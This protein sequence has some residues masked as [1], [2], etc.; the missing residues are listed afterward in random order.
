[1]S[2]MISVSTVCVLFT[3]DFSNHYS[4]AVLLVRTSAV[5]LKL[6]PATHSHPGK[7]P[8]ASTPNYFLQ[9]YIYKHQ[10]PL[11]I[12]T[13]HNPNMAVYENHELENS[14][15]RQQVLN[16]KILC[17]DASH[18]V[19]VS[20]QHT[21]TNYK[22]SPFDTSKL[23]PLTI[24]NLEL[25]NSQQKKAQLSVPSNDDDRIIEWLN[26]TSTSSGYSLPICDKI[27]EV[28]EETKRWQPRQGE[29]S[30]RS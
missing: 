29:L 26:S 24:K 11:K 18:P 17:S 13:S 8:M 14:K 12:T 20:A 2:F 4:I 22:N 21:A 16:K 6:R 19:V 15:K 1:M 7:K 9:N 30:E 25:Y 27:P 28:E 3:W 23:V 5:N 10:K